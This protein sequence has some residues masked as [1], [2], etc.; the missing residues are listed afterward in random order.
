MLGA[1]GELIKRERERERVKKKETYTKRGRKLTWLTL[2]ALRDR[3][4]R[5][6]ALPFVNGDLG[7]A[8]YVYILPP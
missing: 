3:R 2:R 7:E 6:N 8:L 4:K 5:G 1:T